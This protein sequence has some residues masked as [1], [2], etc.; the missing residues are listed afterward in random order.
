MTDDAFVVVRYLSATRVGPEI[1]EASKRFMKF[2]VYDRLGWAKCGRISIGYEKLGFRVATGEWTID[3]RCHPHASTQQL[4]KIFRGAAQDKMRQDCGSRFICFTIWELGVPKD[5][6]KRSLPKKI[7]I[8]A[9]PF[10]VTLVLRHP[11]PS[12]TPATTRPLSIVEIKPCLGSTLR[13]H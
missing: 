2:V 5:Q 9:P 12:L 13:D 1:Q 10:L 11:C 3:V 6:M 7:K 8:L 4:I